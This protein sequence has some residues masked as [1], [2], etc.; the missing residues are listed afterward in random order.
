MQG[1]TLSPLF[2]LLYNN[3][4]QCCILYNAEWNQF[5][6][7]NI[8]IYALQYAHVNY[9]YLIILH[10]VHTYLVEIYYKHKILSLND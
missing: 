8:K 10:V 9:V 3:I 5:I 1:A 4:I 6:K 2:Y 7:L